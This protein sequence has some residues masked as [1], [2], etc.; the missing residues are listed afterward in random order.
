MEYVLQ[1]NNYNPNT[2]KPEANS[3]PASFSPNISLAFV[4]KKNKRMEHERELDE[5]LTV[6]Y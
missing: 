1:V 2:P 3:F 6:L 4:I 5:K